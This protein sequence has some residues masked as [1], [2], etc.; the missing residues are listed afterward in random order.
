MLYIV[1]KFL[2]LLGVVLLL[3]NVTVSAVWKVFA[4]RSGHARTVAH[5]QRMVTGTDWAFT[6]GG[7]LLI[8]G[9]GYGMAALAGLDLLRVRWLF[10]GQVLFLLSGG[11]WLFMLVPLQIRQAQ[12]A[13]RFDDGTIIPD[14]YW[15]LA[16]RWLLWG[17]I[18]T[19][20][21]VV[22]LLLMVAKPG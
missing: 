22:A 5:A 9:G 15:R 16:R 10:W 8:I 7:I 4:D 12:Q 18:A 14:T 20:P 21:L 1:C 13:R 3:G 6:G 2:H 17:V 11:L 19:V